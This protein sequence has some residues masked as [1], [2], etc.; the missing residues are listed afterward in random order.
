VASV[1]IGKHYSEEFVMAESVLPLASVVPLRRKGFRA[2]VTRHDALFTTIAALILVAGFYVKE[3]V[4]EK[5]KDLAASLK[6]GKDNYE[7]SRQLALVSATDQFMNQQMFAVR[8]GGYAD[9]PYLT[10]L[11]NSTSPTYEA[12]RDD[13]LLSARMLDAFPRYSDSLSRR[14]WS[15]KAQLEGPVLRAKDTLES[16][17]RK[18]GFA[19]FVKIVNS[20]PSYIIKAQR[21]LSYAEGAF[22]GQ[23][24]QFI[25]LSQPFNEDV[26]V[27]GEKQLREQEDRVKL[28]TNADYGIFALGSI[29]SLVGK[30]FKLPALGGGGSEG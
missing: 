1:T 8:W 9:N 4:R 5:A 12:S 17:L 14:K 2:F 27:E 7:I 24:I 13:F 26:L 15:L 20:T 28:A 18:D 23:A 30:V 3:V 21:E 29:L 10:M 11:L 16:T 19:A 22:N 25:L 6:T